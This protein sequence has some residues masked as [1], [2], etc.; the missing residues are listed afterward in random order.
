MDRLFI[1]IFLFI[2]ARSKTNTLLMAAN[3]LEIL[4]DHLGDHHMKTVRTQINGSDF[5]CVTDYCCH[6]F[7]VAL[8]LYESA[9]RHS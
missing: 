1:E 7:L 9:S 2:Q 4:I 3:Q 8:L 6:S 5:S